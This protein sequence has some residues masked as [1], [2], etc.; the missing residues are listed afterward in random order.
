VRRGDKHYLRYLENALGSACEV[1]YLLSVCVR[2]K[3][4]RMADCDAFI[5]RYTEVVKGLSALIIRINNDLVAQ[6]QVRRRRRAERA[7][8]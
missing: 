4:L 7:E 8:S 6:S 5:D 1:R 2:L 3:M